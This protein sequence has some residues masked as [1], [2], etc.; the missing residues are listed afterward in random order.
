MQRVDERRVGAAVER[1]E[2]PAFPDA[3]AM[4]R[5]VA[6]IERQALVRA[7]VPHSGQFMDVLV[8][9]AAQRDVE[10]LVTPA[11]RE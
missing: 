1:P 5:A 10:L 11:D 4:A 6:V 2:H 8:Q 9:G 7:V 3:D